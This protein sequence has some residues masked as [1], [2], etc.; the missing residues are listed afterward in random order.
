M[1]ALL[2]IFLLMPFVCK[3]Q[4]QNVMSTEDILINVVLENTAN[5]LK[6]KNQ[7]EINPLEI[8]P[9]KKDSIN[10]DKSSL[11]KWKIIEPKDSI[12]IISDD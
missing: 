7:K 1:K 2:L 8:N 3:S 9:H 12:K 5:Y 6:N 4:D 10:W 11:N